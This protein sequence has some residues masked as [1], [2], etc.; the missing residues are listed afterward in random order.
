[1][2]KAATRAAGLAT[3]PGDEFGPGPTMPMLPR[4]WDQQ[5]DN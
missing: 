2:S 1:M 5:H 4:T 3:L